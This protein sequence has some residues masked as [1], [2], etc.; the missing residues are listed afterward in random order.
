MI[1]ARARGVPRIQRCGLR[2]DLS[3][4]HRRSTRSEP[5]PSCPEHEG[6]GSFSGS[7]AGMTTS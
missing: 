7:I 3:L 2:F 6:L 5:S 4:C 1:G